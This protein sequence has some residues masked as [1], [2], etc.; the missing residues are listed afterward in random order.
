MTEDSVRESSAPSYMLPLLQQR[1][2]IKT[3]WKK[4]K[5]YNHYLSTVVDTTSVLHIWY[6]STVT[7]SPTH[8]MHNATQSQDHMLLW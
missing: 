8:P 5:L 2:G 1:D 7:V 6:F 4:V 3:I